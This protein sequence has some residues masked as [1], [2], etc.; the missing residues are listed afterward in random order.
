MSLLKKPSEEIDEHAARKQCGSGNTMI[1]FAIGKTTILLYLYVVPYFHMLN[2]SGQVAAQGWLRGEGW[3]AYSWLIL[4][5]IL[6]CLVL[7]GS[8]GVIVPSE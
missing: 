8:G 6:G 1:I 7:R 4:Y 5:F 3:F 2:P